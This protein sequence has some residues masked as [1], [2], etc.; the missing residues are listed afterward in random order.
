MDNR[1]ICSPQHFRFPGFEG[2]SSWEEKRMGDLFV[3]II[4]KNKEN[5]K[6]VLTISAQYGLVSQYDYF[7]KNVAS[8]D[9]SNYY[10]IEKGD[11][12]YN[13]SRSQG[14]PYGAIKPLLL[15]DKG[16][17]SPLYI[18]FR[19]KENEGNADFFRHYFETDLFNNEIAKIAQE[20]ARNHGLLNISSEEFFNIQLRVPSIEEQS[21]IAKSLS[22]IDELINASNEKLELLKAHKKGL[23]QQLLTPIN[24]GGNSC[25]T[26]TLRFPKFKNTKGWEIK[27]LENTVKLFT[28]AKKLTLVEYKK[29]GK[30]PIVDQ[31][32]QYISGYTDDG[33][34]LINENKEGVVIF[35]D[36]TCSLKYI[37]F[38]FVQGAD[39]IK[40]FKS[41]E[42]ERV[43]SQYIYY[44]L[45]SVPIKSTEYKRHFS[46]LKKKAVLFPSLVTEQQRLI[47]CFLSIDEVITSCKQKQFILEQHKK[48]LM[49]QLFPKYR[50]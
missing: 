21:K 33:T 36:H 48:G 10:L 22:S 30:Y 15:Y 13:K 43:M 39:G 2:I 31:S 23:M 35:G 3:R 34:A 18:C 26:P 8:L 27:M 17:V 29:S 24:G 25:V 50:N 14:Y 11:F 4:K 40:I 16:V 5:N 28:A 46:D 42:P 20:G 7:N 6:N 44:Y 45:C 32:Q 19:L 9:V 49:Q 1:L 12:A 41:S 38:P 47:E 37:D